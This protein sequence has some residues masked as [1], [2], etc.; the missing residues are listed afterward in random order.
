MAVGEREGDQ[1]E[2]VRDHSEVGRDGRGALGCSDQYPERRRVQS[3]L[4]LDCSDEL[5][6][7]LGYILVQR[8]IDRATPERRFRRQAGGS[9]EAGDGDHFE[10]G[11]T[12]Q[13]VDQGE[14]D[15]VAVG[16]SNQEVDQAGGHTTAPWGSGLYSEGLY[17]TYLTART[18]P[19]VSRVSEEQC[20]EL[21][22]SYLRAVNPHCQLAAQSPTTF[23][24]A[25]RILHRCLVIPLLLGRY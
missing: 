17:V 20:F 8:H 4:Q 6:A 5:L 22:Q 23:G 2:G 24:D 21:M 14:D 3:N 9:G 15:R 18:C 16:G 1:R 7:A 10:G 12:S 25:V 13:G 11:S 19:S